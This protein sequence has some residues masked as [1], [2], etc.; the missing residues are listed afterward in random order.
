MREGAARGVIA[1]VLLLAG[2][3]L[4]GGA[5]LAP[6]ADPVWE[7]GALLGLGS[8]LLVLLL[9]AL[10]RGQGGR[11]SLTH[12]THCRLG[13]L[14]LALAVAHVLVLVLAD[15]LALR[16]LQPS[17]PWYQLA[18]LLALL[19][20]AAL[21]LLAGLP[22]PRG[23][24]RATHLGLCVLAVALLVIHVLVS[25]RYLAPLLGRVAPGAPALALR[26]PVRAGGAP[27]PLS[28]PHQEHAA[29]NCID[30]H[31]NFVDRSGADTCLGCHRSADSGLEHGAEARLHEFCLGCHRTRARGDPHG[32]VAGCA[33]C[34]RR[35]PGFVADG[36]AP[37]QR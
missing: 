23:R 22:G 7:V 4:A 35:E 36:P 1:L 37:P 16:Y 13:W 14:A 15:R 25:E 30:C 28:F 21:A 34:H 8:V 11:W 10:P 19:V 9:G 33:G 3:L 31:H 2:A 5:V 26:E 32:P 6:R 27:L 24:F 20:L 18:G 12:R 29:I 17:L